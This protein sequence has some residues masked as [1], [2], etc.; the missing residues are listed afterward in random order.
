MRIFACQHLTRETVWIPELQSHAN[1]ARRIARIEILSAD[2]EAAAKK[3]SGLIDEPATKTPDGWRVPSGGKRA[4]FL[5]YD[6]AAFAAR[7]PAL[8]AR[9]RRRGGGGHRHRLGDLPRPR[10]PPPPSPMARRR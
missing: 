3:M 9:A 6:A 2:P 5:F 8:C 7:Y 10:R 1:G 4:D